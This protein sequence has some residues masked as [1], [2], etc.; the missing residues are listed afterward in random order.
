MK[1]AI[2]G[3]GNGGH[4]CAFDFSKAGYEVYMYD[5]ES[6]PVNIDAIAAQGGVYGEGELEGFQPVAY[7][8]HDLAKVMEGADKILVVST[9]AGVI[10]FGELCKPFVKPGQMYIVCPGS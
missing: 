7:A 6:F 2:L 4:A 1:V 3:S 5:F 10:P 8:G 9:A